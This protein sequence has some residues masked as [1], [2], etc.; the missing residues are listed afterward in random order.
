MRPRSRLSLGF[1][2]SPVLA[3][4]AHAEELDEPFDLRVDAVLGVEFAKGDR[5]RF[6]AGVEESAGGGFQGFDVGF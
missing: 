4:V 6:L 5:E 2:I 3:D 1:Q